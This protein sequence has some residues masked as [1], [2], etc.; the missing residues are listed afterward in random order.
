MPPTKINKKSEQNEAQ[1]GSL[2]DIKAEL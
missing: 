1:I 2:F